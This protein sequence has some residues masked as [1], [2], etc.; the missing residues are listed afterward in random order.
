MGRKEN[1]R[2]AESE[3]ERRNRKKESENNNSNRQKLW[4]M[5]D[6]TSRHKSQT[7][8]RA[9][10]NIINIHNSPKRNKHSTNSTIS[11][12]KKKRN[13]IFEF[14]SG[15]LPFSSHFV[16][17]GWL[18]LLNIVLLL[19]NFH[20]NIFPYSLL[21]FY[22]YFRRHFLFLSVSLL[23]A[24]NAAYQSHYFI[25]IFHIFTCG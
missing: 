6:Y 12:K 3:A 9:N 21:G 24:I 15:F 8:Q 25:S 19:I 23:T 11:T 20:F 13:F 22:F 4:K 17:A 1:K 14:P 7:K 18:V 2:T 16:Y 10:R 5:K